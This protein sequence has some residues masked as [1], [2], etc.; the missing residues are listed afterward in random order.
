MP[1]EEPLTGGQVIALTKKYLSG[2][3]V[4]FVEKALLYAVDC[5]SGQFRKSGE[6]YIIHPIQ[7]AGILAKLKLDAVTVPVVFAR[8]VEDTDATL[9]DLEREFG[10][11]VRVIVDGV[12]KLGKVKYKSHEEQLAENHRKMLHGHVSRHPCHLGQTS[13]PLAQ[14]ADFEAFTQGQAR[15]DFSRNHGN[16]CTASPPSRDFQRQVGA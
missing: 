7:V 16:L 8:R 11:D 6:P 9:D 12:T 3:D 10:H 2:E 5:H 4:A 13:R 14:H 1:K 15:A